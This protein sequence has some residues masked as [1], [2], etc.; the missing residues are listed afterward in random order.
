VPVARSQL[1][2]IS[3]FVALKVIYCALFA[4]FSLSPAR[5]DGYL[6]MQSPLTGQEIGR[7]YRTDGMNRTE[8]DISNDQNACIKD[9]REH[10]K[11][12]A[13]RIAELSRTDREAAWIELAIAVGP[14]MAKKGWRIVILGGD[15]PGIKRSEIAA[16]DA[17][18]D[19]LSSSLP[20]RIDQ[21]TDLVSVRRY[22]ADVIYTLRV[23]PQ[24]QGMADDIRSFMIVN[25]HTTEAGIKD[26]MKR[27][28]C[29][30]PF[31][32]YL[33]DGF[34]FSWENFDEK[35][36]LWRVRLASNDCL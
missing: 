11:A 30:P 26:L 13:G 6:V 22:K 4:A 27:S 17:V 24:S 23:R 12:D 3:T 10:S 19:K 35:G 29:V 34:A 28:Y 36:L 9:L 8:A 16:L 1:P 5:A 21:H 20:H 15:I 7:A 31:D 14:C 25:P 33:K 18:L 2:R 32:V